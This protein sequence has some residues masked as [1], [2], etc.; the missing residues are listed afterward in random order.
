MTKCQ[1][2]TNWIR[3]NNFHFHSVSWAI[4]CSFTCDQFSLYCCLFLGRPPIIL[5]SESDA[6]YEFLCL[7]QCYALCCT[8]A[9]IQARTYVHLHAHAQ[10]HTKSDYD[11]NFFFL[12]SF[13]FFI[14]WNIANNW[15]VIEIGSFCI[16]PLLFACVLFFFILSLSLSL[17]LQ[18]IVSQMIC[19]TVCLCNCQQ[20]NLKAV[21]CHHNVSSV[22]SAK[23]HIIKWPEIMGLWPKP[24]QKKNA[25]QQAALNARTKYTFIDTVI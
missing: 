4:L 21:E 11:F 12:S 18:F 3:R 23:W 16:I 14:F 20:S 6:E 15:F 25:F 7:Q 5:L 24:K 2:I 9:Q 8:C 19:L 13:G 10:A 17:C 1:V 22:C